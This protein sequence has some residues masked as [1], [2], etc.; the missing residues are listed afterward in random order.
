MLFRSAFICRVMEHKLMEIDKALL[1][2]PSLR[3]GWVIEHRDV[4]RELLTD[5]GL[6]QFSRRYYRN[7][8]TGKRSYLVDDLVGIEPFE[9]VEAGLSARLCEASVD[10]SY[11]KSSKVCCESQ[12]SR[13][14]VMN[15]TRQVTKCVLEPVETRQ[16]VPVIHIQAA[17]LRG[18][19]GVAGLGSAPRVCGDRPVVAARHRGRRAESGR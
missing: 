10:H 7:Q 18:A 5:H 14:T 8:K 6:L 13:Q 1:E 15:K 4:P 9:R 3:K 11:Q 17:I 12:V 2:T 19:D 16:D